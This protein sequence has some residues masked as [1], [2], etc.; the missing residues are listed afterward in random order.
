[1]SG[2]PASCTA[3][4]PASCT[5]S[6]QLITTPWPRSVAMTLCAQQHIGTQASQQVKTVA[7]M[8]SRLDKRT[9]MQCCG[10][11]LLGARP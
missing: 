5:R 8:P 7:A 11:F 10:R 9:G 2:P 1:M 6:A 4:A 3:T